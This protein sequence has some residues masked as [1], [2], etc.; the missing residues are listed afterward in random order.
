MKRH[1]FRETRCWVYSIEWQKRGLPQAHILIWL[2]EKKPPSKTD[3]IS[4]EILDVTID[5]VLFQ[6][7]VQ[8]M[9]HAPCASPY[10]SV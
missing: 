8:N 9:F 3:Q 6:I 4:A 2:I 7:I 5:P 1:V 10:M